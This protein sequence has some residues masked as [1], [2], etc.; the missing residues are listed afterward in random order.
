SGGS[1]YRCAG[2]SRSSQEGDVERQRERRDDDEGDQRRPFRLQW[3]GGHRRGD[4]LLERR[5]RRFVAVERRHVGREGLFVLLAGRAITPLVTDQVVG[6]ERGG[7]LA[8][9]LEILGVV[10][11]R[12][13]QRHRVWLRGGL[14]VDLA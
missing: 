7:D 13:R 2:R 10:E 1:P 6:L 8:R 3:R 11:Y 9:R 12:D 5:R 4:G 14:G